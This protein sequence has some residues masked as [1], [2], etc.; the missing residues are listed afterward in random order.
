MYIKKAKKIVYFLARSTFIRFSPKTPIYI[1]HHIPKCGGTSL[2]TVLE[3]W[4]LTI[5]D[6]RIGETLNYPRKV[7]INKLRSGHCLCGHFELDGNYLYQRYPEAL[8]SDKYKMFTFV[9]DPLDI[10]MSLWRYEKKKNTNRAKSIEE[11]LLLRPNYLANRFPATKDN[12]KSV[13]DR[14]FFVG[15]LE[16]Y[17]SGIDLLAH[18][19]GK[20]VQKVPWVNQTKNTEVVE[21]PKSVVARFKQENALDYLIYNYC[22]DAFKRTL[23]KNP[24]QIGN[25][26][27]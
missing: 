26:Y 16:D 15:I 11:H 12:Y 9:R 19:L 1:F 27:F 18:L 22:F 25:T 23:D 3:N 20:K 7:N 21:L 8:N 4:F 14:Y 13:I 24:S 5:K 10:Q 2:L 6:Y 17:Q